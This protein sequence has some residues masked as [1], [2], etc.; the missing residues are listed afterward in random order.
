MYTILTTCIAHA[1][2]RTIR[3]LHYK[4]NANIFEIIYIHFI[5]SL[6]R[7]AMLYLAII[8]NYAEDICRILHI[9]KVFH[10]SF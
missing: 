1:V 7:K 10:V 4:D 8:T 6:Q 2:C 9:A 3:F 5:V